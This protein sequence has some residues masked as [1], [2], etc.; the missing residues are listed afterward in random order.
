MALTV[1]VALSYTLQL[2]LILATLPLLVELLFLT[3]GI[4]RRIR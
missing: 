1:L 2:L 4:R 3:L